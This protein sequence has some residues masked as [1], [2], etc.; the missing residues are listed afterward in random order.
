MKFQVLLAKFLRVDCF[1]ISQG[2]SMPQG[3]LVARADC[4]GSS[5]LRIII[6]VSIIINDCQSKAIAVV[7][8]EC[9]LSS[10]WSSPGALFCRRVV[11]SGNFSPLACSEHNAR[12][13]DLGD[14]STEGA[15]AR[16]PT[17]C[18]LHEPPRDVSTSSVVT[19]SCC[20]WRIMGLSREL[21][22]GN[23]CLGRRY[24]C[25]ECKLDDARTQTAIS[26]ALNRQA[27]WFSASSTIIL[28]V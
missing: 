3:Q 24:Y 28:G 2:V 4:H 13:C 6:A 23:F 14:C 19:A 9:R 20:E 25:V 26:I 10:S 5:L 21:S 12:G 17:P 8:S 27:I 1:R 7:A 18:W 15:I 22:E 11:V 16:A